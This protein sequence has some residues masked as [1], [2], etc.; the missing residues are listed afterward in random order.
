MSASK[1]KKIYFLAVFLLFVVNS[2]AMGN[3]VKGSAPMDLLEI[4][5]IYSKAK[6][7]FNT[8]IQS[9][10]QKANDST[11]SFEPFKQGV[12]GYL[13]MLKRNEIKHD[14]YLTIIDFSK[15]STEERLYIFD[16]CAQELVFSTV[17]AHGQ[18]SGG[19]YA[20][21]F[22]NK[23]ESHQSSIGFYVTTSTY[24]SKKY[25]LALRIDGKEH[26]NNHASSRGIVIHGAKYAS[27]EYIHKYGR[28][29]RSFGCPALP[30]EY[31]KRV[32]NMIKGGTCLY[33][34]Y[35]SASYQRYSKYL[36]RKDYLIDFIP[37]SV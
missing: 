26:T 36:N 12:I 17:V 15:P 10:Y 34:Y 7:S 31:T 5:T 29:G 28:L 20:T 6:N 37:L 19:L 4:D 14:R 32:I 18:N 23:D 25:D 30:Y 1:T 9:L 11:L 8:Y 3:M 21:K 33:I 27:Y 24:T 13:N 2:R 22:S 35:P 16:A